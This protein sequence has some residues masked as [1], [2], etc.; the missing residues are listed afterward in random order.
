[1]SRKSVSKFL[2]LFAYVFVLASMPVAVF[3]VSK[4]TNF[5]QRAI[6]KEADIYVYIGVPTTNK[7]ASVWKNLS[8]GGEN[9]DRMFKSLLGYINVIEP[10][11]IRID[12]IYDRYDVV[13]KDA[14]GNLVYNWSKLDLT[15]ND[16]LSTGATPYLSLSYTP[17]VLT[18]A[19]YVT[20]APNN[21][22]EWERLVQ[23]TIERYSGTGSIGTQDVYY[24][25]WNEPD[26][27]GN[28]KIIGDKSYLDLYYHS[29]LAAQRASNTRPYKLGGPATTALYK[30]WFDELLKFASSNNLRLDFF[31]WHRYSNN[32]SDYEEDITN[33]RNWLA[34]YPSYNNIEFVISE[35]G[36][37]ST[38]TPAN[39]NTIGAIH[40]I[41][42]SAALEDEIGKG[43]LFGIKDGPNDKQSS[44]GWGM[45][46]NEGF[47][48][49]K[50]KP[51]YKAVQ[52]LNSMKG[53]GAE[54]RGEGTWVKTFTKEDGNIVRI[55]VVNY[56]E[57]GKH[58]E[59]VPITIENLKTNKF[60]F[61]RIDFQGGSNQKTVE[62]S[63]PRWSTRE[64]FKPNTAAIFEIVP[65]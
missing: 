2:R 63:E 1:M 34:K 40:T 32:L 37:S 10:E 49:Q 9:E 19:G 14:S 62:V 56:D 22:S 21:W 8:Q 39:N 41:A 55:L 28:F 16:I 27:F 46:A 23:A 36:Y 13:Q 53:V 5:F 42:V 60:I 31:S 61:R 35:I 29:A 51:R 3:L 45:I 52:F 24:E 25:V 65:Q 12:H 43:I 54:T 58:S 57:K 30:A 64:Y 20:E 38:S 48:G 7:D 15:I 33:T 50:A 11:Y 26:L 18:N 44:E 6:G 17:K 59:S 47:E 4:Q